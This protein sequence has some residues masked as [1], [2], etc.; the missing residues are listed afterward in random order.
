[1]KSVATLVIDPPPVQKFTYTLR[2]QSL[3]VRSTKPTNSNGNAWRLFSK[4]QRCRWRQP[5]PTANRLAQ[6]FQEEPFPFRMP[7]EPSD[8]PDRTPTLTDE[9][10]KGIAYLLSLPSSRYLEFERQA[11]VLSRVTQPLMDVLALFQQRRPKSR[12]FGHCFLKYLLDQGL[13]RNTLYWGWSSTTWRSVIDA[14][15]QQSTGN[16]G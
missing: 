11:R 9:E 13:K 12:V 2:M 7:I 6:T 1:M 14:L 16:D 15:G 8:Y 3:H 5:M 10:L 4:S